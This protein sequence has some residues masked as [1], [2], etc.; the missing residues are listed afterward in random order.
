MRRPTIA[1]DATNAASSEYVDADLG[2]ENRRGR[3]RRGANLT[4][5]KHVSDITPAHLR[6]LS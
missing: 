6:N 3:H 2:R 1:V 5:R 4:S